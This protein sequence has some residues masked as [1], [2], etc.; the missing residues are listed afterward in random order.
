MFSP[1]RTS[2]KLIARYN[3]NPNPD[4]IAPTLQSSVAV[5]MSTTK[6]NPNPALSIESNQIKKNTQRVVGNNRRGK[7]FR[8][9]RVFLGAQNNPCPD[10]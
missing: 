5:A 6:T 1:A 2:T 7:E 4:L 10:N 9:H 3:I 8:G